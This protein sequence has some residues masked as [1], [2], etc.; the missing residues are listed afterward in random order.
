MSVFLLVLALLQQPGL[1]PGAGSDVIRGV[2]TDVTGA[3]VAGVDVVVLSGTSRSVG[4]TAADG[5]WSAAVPSGATMASLHVD[6]AGF[7]PLTR[8]VTLPAQA[9]HLELRPQA[10]AEKVTVTADVAIT[11]LSIDSSVTSIE[12]SSIASAPAL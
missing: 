11:R 4:R 5:A 3:P 12:R 9:V 8:A 1:P 10:I 2:V 6:V 7:A